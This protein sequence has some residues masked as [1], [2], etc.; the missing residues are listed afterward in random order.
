VRRDQGGFTLIE[1]G[2]VVL[3]FGL[4]VAIVAP[5]IGRYTED[6]NLKGAVDQMA[7]AV[8]LTR[9]R[10]MATRIQRTVHFE[11][12]VSGTDYHTVDASGAPQGGWKLPRGITYAWLPGTIDSVTVTPDGRCNVSGLV[13][14]RAVHGAQ[15]TVSV[16]TSGLVLTQ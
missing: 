2:I 16:L 13:I 11:A 9:D 10:A 1:L 6:L 8:R 3:V 4:L 12:G 14:L 5:A 7:N 15:D